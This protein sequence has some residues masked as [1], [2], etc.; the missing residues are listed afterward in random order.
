MERILKEYEVDG[1]YFDGWCGHREDFRPGYHLM[2][3]ARAILGDRLLYLHSSSEPF[4]NCRVYL[5]F[6][7]T[8]ADFVLS[9]EA[10]RF[11]LGLEEFLRYMVSGH[12]ISNSVGMWCYY[13]SWSDEPGYH[14]VVPKAE[15]IEMALRNYVRLWR[16]TQAWSKKSPGNL[17]RFDRE[18]YGGLAQLRA[19]D[20]R[21]GT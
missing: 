4:G 17:A 6:V 11:G 19:A 2:R 14:N 5:P 10:G 20:S 18:Y 7:Y 13:G 16:N 15:H 3:R 1:L 21:D 8:Y 12:Q 9:G